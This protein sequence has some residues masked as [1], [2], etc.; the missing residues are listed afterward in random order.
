MQNQDTR[1]LIVEAV[2]GVA[3]L[4]AIATLT[5]LLQRLIVDSIPFFEATR[6]SAL[7]P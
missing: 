5:M 3:L 7:L 4:A 6:S 1:E 2:V